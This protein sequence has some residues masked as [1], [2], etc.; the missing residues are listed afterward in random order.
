MKAAF[1]TYIINMQIIR[2]YRSIFIQIVNEESK[3]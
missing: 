2:I 1:K 3:R